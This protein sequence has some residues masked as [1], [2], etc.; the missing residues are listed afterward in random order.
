[1]P[2]RFPHLTVSHILTVPVRNVSIY[3]CKHEI[4]QQHQ[5]IQM[6]YVNRMIEF[7]LTFLHV[8][9]VFSAKQ[10]KISGYI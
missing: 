9:T 4:V 2:K 8:R 6:L 5:K 1:M 3:Q 7:N 10:K